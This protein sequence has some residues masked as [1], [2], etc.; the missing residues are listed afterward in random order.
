MEWLC[1]INPG[2]VLTSVFNGIP[3][4]WALVAW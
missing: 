1:D 4:M 3:S 2:Q